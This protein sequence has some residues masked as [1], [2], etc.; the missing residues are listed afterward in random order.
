M[1]TIGT[2]TRV[3]KFSNGARD[4][5]DSV[6]EMDSFQN[7]SKSNILIPQKNTEINLQIQF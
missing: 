5:S 6:Q 2:K 7:N 1:L 3:K 4:F